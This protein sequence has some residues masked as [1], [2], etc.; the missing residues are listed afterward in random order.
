MS[1]TLPIIEKHIQLTNVDQYGN[2]IVEY[3][4]NTGYDVAIDPSK[5]KTGT[6]G[7]SVLPQNLKNLQ[8]LINMIGAFAFKTSLS[9]QDFGDD[10]VTQRTDISDPG[11]IADARVIKK[12]TDVINTMYAT[13]RELTAGLNDIKSDIN[14]FDPSLY[15]KVEELTGTLNNL[16]T[17]LKSYTDNQFTNGT[18]AKYL[19]PYLLITDFNK[20]IG[21]FG[22]QTIKAYIDA[23][24]ATIPDV[25]LSNYVT[26]KVMN[27]RIGLIPT[28]TVKEYIDEIKKSIPDIDVSTL[29]TLKYVNNKLG[30]I[31]NLSVSEY[32]LAAVRNSGVDLSNYIT[33]S[34]LTSKIGNLENTGLSVTAYINYKLSQLD[35]SSYVTNTELKNLLGTIP[36][37]KTVE[38]MIADSLT[39]SKKYT[40]SKVGSGT[41]GSG[42]GT[43]TWTEYY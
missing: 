38:G 16:E 7:Q 3:V 17:K 28:V 9:I 41:G 14:N 6:N 13:I 21:D 23:V 36:S 11:H 39:E 5:N 37:N 25:D 1:N 32:V 15:V 4:A 20:K 29:A 34:D 27:D 30:D 33:F 31:G 43:I 19:E 12:M 8:Q 2:E 40:D 26:Y 35:F 10:V 22:D 18:L 24:A 42:N